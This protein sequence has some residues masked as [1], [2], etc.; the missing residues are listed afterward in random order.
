MKPRCY[1]V[2]FDCSD[3]RLVEEAL[4][5][6]LEE[7]LQ[8]QDMLRDRIV[9]VMDEYHMLARRKKEEFLRWLIP[10]LSCLKVVMI[11]NRSDRTDF[12]MWETLTAVDPS[13]EQ[14]PF[15]G[16]I[17]VNKLNEVIKKNY[18]EETI[19]GRTAYIKRFSTFLITLR[20][21]LSDDAISLRLEPEF[22]GKKDPRQPVC[23]PDYLKLVQDKLIIF[24]DY[25]VEAILTA[26]D[27][28]LPKLIEKAPNPLDLQSIEDFYR[29]AST[30]SA[31]RL[32]VLTALLVPYMK[33]DS[34]SKDHLCDRARCYREVVSA[35]P[36][37]GKAHPAVKI[38]VWI[39]YTLFYVGLSSL[40][41]DAQMIE[42]ILEKM[43]TLHLCDLPDFPIILGEDPLHMADISMSQASYEPL[44]DYKDL[45]MFKETLA[46][47]CAINWTAAKEVW[48]K[49]PVTDATMLASIFDEPSA[50]GATIFKALKADN[51]MQLLKKD[52]AMR[53]LVL[54]KKGAIGQ[55]SKPGYYPADWI[56][57][58]CEATNPPY[59]SPY[60][61][62]VWA[63]MTDQAPL[64]ESVTEMRDAMLARVR[65]L[66]P[67]SSLRLGGNTIAAARRMQ[68]TFLFWVSEHGG[69]IGAI[70]HCDPKTVP[71]G[72]SREV[73]IAEMA[74]RRCTAVVAALS[75]LARE[76]FG[77]DYKS[78]HRFWSGKF[79]CS[80][81]RLFSR[82]GETEVIP[83]GL[84]AE[85]VQTGSK[86]HAGWSRGLST[87]DDLLRRTPSS[88][89][90]LTFQEAQTAI[91]ELQ[92]QKTFDTLPELAK[93]KVLGALLQCSPSGLFSDPVQEWLM[94]TSTRI[95]IISSCQSATW[96]AKSSSSQFPSK[97][98]ER[99][100]I[101]CGRSA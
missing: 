14:L 67:A 1:F 19:F 58:Q 24:R 72:K 78:A 21:M 60:L 96:S 89:D 90:V 33:Y 8:S 101:S 85:M 55:Q 50:N 29:T 45:E 41:S 15:E 48:D 22:P 86:K 53:H 97:L 75:I 39:Q 51:V 98:R 38:T 35:V 9:L 57:T 56:R 54:G 65:E 99:L 11:A 42:G 34:N 4:I 32:V 87:L 62:S 91:E 79:V 84:A 12:K 88:A 5:D 100:G 10:R 30:Q 77:Q 76:V 59:L 70:G 31:I 64:S 46:R 63:E 82:D 52:P 28:L 16:R 66:V 17:S 44:S 25:G 2:K 80:E 43:R 26:F 68:A 27:A 81:A 73:V 3:D 47:R 71:P 61:Y 20:G 94:I 13:I 83:L 69:S 37:L 74:A 23:S 40:A 6:L 49:S 36:D 95:L 92:L 93:P 18:S 7:K